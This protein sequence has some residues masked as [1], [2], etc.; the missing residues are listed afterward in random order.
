MISINRVNNGDRHYDNKTVEHNSILIVGQGD[1][2]YKNKSI[3]YPTSI[4]SMKE[5]YGADSELT[6]AYTEAKE[7]GAT[8]VFVLNC[9]RFTDYIEV[10]TSISQTDF[11]YV[12]PLFE[13]STVFHDPLLG[14]ERHLCEIYSNA[15]EDCCSTVLLTDSHAGLNE[16][17]DHFLLDMK[18]KNMEFQ[19][20]GMHRLQSGSNL[21][22]VLN[23]LKEYKHANV[24]LA[25]VL[26]NCDMRY[27]PQQNLG[28]VVF[29]INNDDLYGHE[30]AYFAYNDLSG[31]TIENFQNYYGTPSPEKMMII[32]IIKNRIEM[33]LD[34]NQ[35]SGKL[36]TKYLKIQIESYTKKIMN[37]F[38][39]VLI[40][41]FTLD[42]IRYM[43]T[44]NTG[45]F[46]ARVYMSIKPY[47]SIEAI[48]M[49]MEV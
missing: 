41:N 46:E 8:Q 29:D 7:C 18:K 47:N 49:E 10:L 32:T 13:F 5:M 34:Y 21:G 26:S 30:V 12:C 45:E 1:R 39:G 15:L 14:Q 33:A 36:I 35:F 42:E 4:E 37:E 2:D 11:A 38:I 3:V 17:I 48:S 43:K 22:F 40:E 24:V 19:E 44:Q 9:L 20:L 27:Y 25:A 16:D 28:D 31:T 6:M 23:N